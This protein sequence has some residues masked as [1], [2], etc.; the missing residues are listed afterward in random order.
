MHMMPITSTHLPKIY[1]ESDSEMK[2]G[3]L[4]ANPEKLADPPCRPTVGSL[5]ASHEF[6]IS[7]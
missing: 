6:K 4:T 5:G 2:A 3:Q 1:L 7:N